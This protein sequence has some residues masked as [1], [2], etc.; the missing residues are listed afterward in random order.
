MEP[1][2]MNVAVDSISPPG[3]SPAEDPAAHRWYAGQGDSQ[4]P[5]APTPRC[6]PPTM[7][8]RAIPCCA[9]SSPMRCNA[10]GWWWTRTPSKPPSIRS[11]RP[12]ARWPKPR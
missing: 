2:S 11:P 3:R 10:T 7:S 12:A 8:G 6:C 4:T 1:V 9:R 5:P